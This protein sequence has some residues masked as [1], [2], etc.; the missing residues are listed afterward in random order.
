MLVLSLLALVIAYWRS[1]NDCAERAA[2]VPAHPMKAIVYCD[3]GSPEVLR[4]ENIEK[5]IP[6]D[7]QVLIRV[8]A[9]SANPL[10][11]H[12]MRGEP[13]VMRLGTGLRKPKVTRLG[14]D[15]AGTVEA[16]GRNVK[17]FKS[18]DAVF[19][20][21]TGAF[22][23]YVLASERGLVTKPENM[24]FEQTASVPVAAIT[25][26]Q[27][28]R[29]KGKVQP[30]QKVLINGASGGVGTFAVQIAK[31]FGAHVTGVCSTRNVDLVRSIGADDVIDYTRQDYTGSDQRYDVI[32]DMVGNHPVSAHKRVL[33]PK[34]IYVI[35]GGPKGRWLAPMDRVVKASLASRFGS[36]KFVMLLASMNK[37]DLTILRDLMQTGKVTPVIDRRY[38]LAQ[39]PQAIEY[40]ETGRARGKVVIS[41]GD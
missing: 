10:D 21:K 38:S 40:L 22:A 26:L 5:P 37:E 41:V 19:G 2:K 7:D 34:G 1:D 14:V 35:V 39:V 33:N 24:T 32:V 8:R 12:Y 28:L 29:D 3:Y 25:A 20:A 23:E 17:Q 11:W 27:A 13:N 36:Q 4:L 9:A 18:G 6:G 15:F 16:V 30:G 31:S